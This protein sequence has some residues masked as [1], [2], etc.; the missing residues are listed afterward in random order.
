MASNKPSQGVRFGLLGLC[1]SLKPRVGIDWSRGGCQLNVVNMLYD[2]QGGGLG[3][4][5]PSDKV[6]ST[7]AL[8]QQCDERKIRYQQLILPEE[9][10]R[11]PEES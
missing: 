2:Q 11:S 6:V 8:L 1:R 4:R 9:Q 10:P 3:S 5:P 7:M